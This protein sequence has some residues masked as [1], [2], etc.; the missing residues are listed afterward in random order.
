MENRYIKIRDTTEYNDRNH[1]TKPQWKRYR[2]KKNHNTKFQ[3]SQKEAKHLDWSPEQ[4]QNKH[5]WTPIREGKQESSKLHTEK[6]V[7]HKALSAPMTHFRVSFGEAAQHAAT[8][9]TR[10]AKTFLER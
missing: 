9:N 1:K 4:N 2:Q 10:L 8:W 5:R 7:L 6:H 3:K